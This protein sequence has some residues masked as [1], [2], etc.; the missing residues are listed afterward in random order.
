MCSLLHT[1]PMLWDQTQL[2][3]SARRCAQDDTFSSRAAT[4][5]VLARLKDS[6]L[7]PISSNVFAIGT[8]VL[9]TRVL[10]AAAAFI[11]SL[12]LELECEPEREPSR[13]DEPDEDEGYWSTRSAGDDQR[14]IDELGQGDHQQRA[15]GA[16]LMPERAA[17]EP[18]DVVATPTAPAA[19]T[20]PLA[21]TPSLSDPSPPK[22]I[23][24]INSLHLIQQVPELPP[25]PPTTHDLSFLAPALCP[26]AY[27]AD[28]RPAH[29]FD[30]RFSPPHEPRPRSAFTAPPS[31]P[32]SYYSSLFPSEPVASTSTLPTPA[33]LKRSPPRTLPAGTH[34]IP[35]VTEDDDDD[36]FFAT[37]PSFPESHSSPPSPRSTARTLPP[38]PKP[39]RKPRRVKSLGGRRA[40]FDSDPDARGR[41]RSRS[42]SSS[43]TRTSTSPNPKPSA[44]VDED[45]SD[46]DPRFVDLARFRKPL[47]GR[48]RSSASASNPFVGDEFRLVA[49]GAAKAQRTG[50]GYWGVD[51]RELQ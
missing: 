1:Q 22:P 40:L 5:L 34:L 45:E 28:E 24:T 35:H 6:P 50:E 44:P 39:A 16:T 11:R 21:R 2:T 10:E 27:L 30:P 46:D 23:P 25:S 12:E 17:P 36:A 49:M 42:H 14:E 47:A 3:R 9:P 15:R 4:S 32:E 51:P 37:L 41:Q 13:T 20:I 18:V 19:S 38:A 48:R 31:S 26:Y 7:A 29:P 33:S 43:T 8:L